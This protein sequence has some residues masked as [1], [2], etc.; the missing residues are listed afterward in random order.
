M[1]SIIKEY[2]EYQTIIRGYTQKVILGTWRELVKLADYLRNLSLTFE[3]V[4]LVH[5]ENYCIDRT[6]SKSLGYRNLIV[7]QIRSF[8]TYLQQQ[9]YRSPSVNLTYANLD[10]HQALPEVASLEEIQDCLKEL[11]RQ[12]NSILRRRQFDPIWKRNLAIFA[13]MYATG[14]RAGEVANLLLRDVL[15]E[16]QV[17]CIR[18]G[19]GRKD[20]RVPIVGEVLELLQTY[21]A[22]RKNLHLD[23]PLF[24]TWRKKEMD[25]NLVGQT[26]R[27]Y[28][29]LWSKPLRPHQLRHYVESQVMGSVTRKYIF[30]T[31]FMKTLSIM[32]RKLS[33]VNHAK[34]ALR[35]RELT[36]D[37][38]IG[39]NRGGLALWGN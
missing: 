15:W 36:L 17:L 34:K 2:R 4:T 14:I 9:E 28:S 1:E 26:F 32:N 20:R 7:S 27:T 35:E 29:K 13:L 10:A 33:E 8:F 18:A 12:L 16:E 3:T 6:K 11:R 25:N 31:F 21:L 23:A 24:L 38:F 19:K 37:N 22:T 5:L 30:K 39:R